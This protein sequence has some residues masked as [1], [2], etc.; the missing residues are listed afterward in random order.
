MRFEKIKQYDLAKKKSLKTK[1]DLIRNQNQVHLSL[2]LNL[3]L[4]LEW[5]P[6]EITESNFRLLVKKIDIFTLFYLEKA[7]NNF[8]NLKIGE[9]DRGSILDMH[10]FRL[11]D[12]G[13]YSLI[14]FMIQIVYAMDNGLPTKKKTKLTRCWSVL[15]S[16]RGLN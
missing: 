15:E 4:W 12:Y 6:G 10:N 9:P 14:L 13:R 7:L 3:V 2:S 1:V 11:I 8:K 5:I 16:T